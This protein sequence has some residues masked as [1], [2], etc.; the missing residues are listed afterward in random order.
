MLGLV[1]LALEVQIVLEW[2]ILSAL[3][4]GCAVDC[5]IEFTPSLFRDSERRL[6]EGYSTMSVT[7]L[8]S[9]KGFNILCFGFAKVGCSSY[10]TFSK[11]LA[12]TCCP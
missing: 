5:D 2:V 6:V 4:D 12:C 11:T 7:E 10:M 3:S 9:V 1:A 8:E